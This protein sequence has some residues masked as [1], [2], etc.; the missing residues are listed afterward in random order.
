MS[1]FASDAGDGCEF[2][3]IAHGQRPELV[4]GRESGCVAFLHPEP[5]TCGHLLVIPERHCQ[6]LYEIDVAQLRA[7]TAVA[8]HWALAARDR[9]GA[10]GVNVLTACRPA[11]WQQVFHFHW[12]VIPRYADDGMSPP[13]MPRPAELQRLLD[14]ARRLT[15][16][17]AQS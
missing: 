14:V 11:A 5:A 6:D 8:Q 15:E 2:C 17:A 3:A 4:V 13:W 16:D 12:H 7:S 1:R 9:L 10:G